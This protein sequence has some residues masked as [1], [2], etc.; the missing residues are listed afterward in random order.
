MNEQMLTWGASDTLEMNAIQAKHQQDWIYLGRQTSAE[1]TCLPVVQ[2]KRLL[3]VR[4]PWHMHDETESRPTRSCMLT[5]G[6]C[7]QTLLERQTPRSVL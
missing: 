1:V 2:K 5:S 4:D 3:V 7:S 6:M